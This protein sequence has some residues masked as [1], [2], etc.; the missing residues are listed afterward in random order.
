[1]A[2]RGPL[3]L[4]RRGVLA[5]AVS[6]AVVLTGCSTLF[7]PGDGAD[8]EAPP[9][10]TNS[11]LRVVIFELEGLD[12]PFHAGLIIPTP[13]TTVIFD[14]LGRWEPDQCTREGDLIRNPTAQDEARY[15]ARDG[16]GPAGATWTL[17]H[18]ETAVPP[19]VSRQALALAEQ[20]PPLPPLHCAYAVSSLLS[21]LPGFSYVEPDVV[22]ADLL[23]RL[24]DRP[25]FVYSRRRLD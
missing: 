1:M 8:I 4:G 24:R 20:T 2:D 15:L 3:I 21:R 17:H 7:E 5:G 12:L 22:T 16:V 6:A 19:A 13:E 9:L 14:P 23:R 10:A 18:L 11:K 25:E